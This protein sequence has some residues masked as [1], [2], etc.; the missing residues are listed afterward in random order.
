MVPCR[1]TT[2]PG[3]GSKMKSPSVQTVAVTGASGYVG[4]VLAE[5]LRLSAAFRVVPLVRNPKT[6][7]DLPWSFDAQSG[8]AESLR[9][10]A[11][12]TLIHSAWD[13]RAS[14][15]AL[16]EQTCVRGSQTLLEAAEQAGLRR[17]I[18]IS[19]MSSFPGCRSVY[20]RTKLAVEQLF[21]ARG[22]IVLRLGLVHGE[23]PGGV[24]GSLRDQVRTRSVVPLIG[25]GR[26]PQYLLDDRDLAEAMRRVTGGAADAFASAPLTLANPRPWPFRT[27]VERIAAAEHRQVRL[28]PIPWRLLH[29]GLRFAERLGL[30][31]PVRSDSVLGFVHADPA[32][33]CSGLVR[34]GI[35]P[36]DLSPANHP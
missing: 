14:S 34:L 1:R 25:S 31:L 11:V 23:N 9:A 18:F 8:L 16:M 33:D 4:S 19:S 30:T 5:A 28:V 10:R 36:H 7:D 32:P 27:L 29:T 35:T 21:L 6:P 22:G 17:L 24:F 2:A 15:P 12:D 3:R 20:G 26:I 13:M